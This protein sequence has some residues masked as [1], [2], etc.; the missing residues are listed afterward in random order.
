MPSQTLP[1]KKQLQINARSA[2]MSC[3]RF[4]R[5]DLAG[6]EASRHS[7]PE[8]ARAYISEAMLKAHA[9]LIGAR[10]VLTDADQA[11]Y[12]MLDSIAKA[13][14]HVTTADNPVATV[15]RLL[16][17]LDSAG[18]PRVSQPKAVTLIY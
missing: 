4:L 10:T 8:R 5:D 13:V 17:A 1:L 16:S 3:L 15:E 7:T 12:D 9:M 18:K 14:R 6:I 2:A 11:S